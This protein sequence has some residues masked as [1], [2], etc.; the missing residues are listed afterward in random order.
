MLAGKQV[1]KKKYQRKTVDTENL[2]DIFKCTSCGKV[3]LSPLRYF[4]KSAYNLAYSKNGGYCHICIKCCENLFMQ[5][6]SNYNDEKMALLMIC[7]ETGWFFSE[8]IYSQVKQ[9]NP[10]KFKLG[11]YVRM[12]NLS[13][14]KTMT[15]SDYITSAIK[16]EKFLHQKETVNDNKQEEWSEDSLKNKEEVIEVIGYDPFL[17]YGDSDRQYLFNDFIRYLDEDTIEDT[18]KLSQI[19]QIIN[20][21]NQ[22][23]RYDLLIANL[24]PLADGSVITKLNDMKNKL[25]TSNDKIAKENEIS[26]KNRSNKDI[27]KSTLTY[28]MKD[29]REKDF[30]RAEADYYE[31]LKSEGTRWAVE[32]SVDAIRKNAYFD[33]NDLNEIGDIRRELVNKLQNQ[34][35][36]LMEEKRQLLLEIQ[37]LKGNGDS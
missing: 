8:E 2:P 32:L 4:Y 21:N 19:M 15:F 27:G 30:E 35:D 31:Q 28:L 10:D 13:Q 14:N 18:Y 36:D 5:Y 25:V 23:R 24:N 34:V 11:E 37:E 33:E 3:L 1:S 26:V 22:I 7:S 16:N 12:L 20:N 17:G 6:K 9:K 29:L